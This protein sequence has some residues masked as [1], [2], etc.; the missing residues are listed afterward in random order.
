MRR[1]PIV[2]VI[3]LFGLPLLLSCRGCGGHPGR[4]SGHS[5]EVENRSRRN[6]EATT[7]GSNDH[8]SS[9]TYEG[10]A[11]WENSEY[12]D[13]DVSSDKTK[14]SESSET[15]NYSVSRDLLI[16]STEGVRGIVSRIL[17]RKGYVSSFNNQTLLPNWVA[18][19]LTSD[20]TS[21]PVKRGDVKFHED[22]D[23]PERYRVNT[24]DYS[25]SGYDRGHMCPAGDN[26]WD[27]EA[28]DQC[29]LLTNICPQNQHLNAGD[30]NE[31]ENKCRKWAQQYGEIYIVCGPILFRNNTKRIGKQ[32]KITVP[33]AFFKV[34][35]RLGE[36]PRAIGFI[37]RN[38]EGNRPM[39]DYVNSVDQVE[40]ITG[41]DFFH[42]LP[43]NVEK[44]VEA[45]GEL[46]DWR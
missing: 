32:R 14:H 25:R 2:L 35:L 9:N 44:V 29:F 36:E 26:K 27:E 12:S 45:R 41:Y 15:T 18:W 11:Q 19:E 20:H 30:W 6:S 46:S 24:F 22:M 42:A 3:C 37:Y 17:Y 43:D 8:S 7:E 21:G 34:V 5:M 31:M 33:D 10:S 1:Y 4:L 23:V 39:G 40:R 16:P 38:Q 28:M 13:D